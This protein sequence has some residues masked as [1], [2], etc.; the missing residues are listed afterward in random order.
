M[1]A[2]RR[3]LAPRHRLAYDLWSTIPTKRFDWQILEQQGSFFHPQDP[4]FAMN[5]MT[6]SPSKEA[7]E[8]RPYRSLYAA[9]LFQS[10]QDAL[11]AAMPGDSPDDRDEAAPKKPRAAAGRSTLVPQ[12]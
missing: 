4:S 12:A 7:R 2:R 1:P 3:G 8:H 11:D 10:F 6:L 5:D 9:L